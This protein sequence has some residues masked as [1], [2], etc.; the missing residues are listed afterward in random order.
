MTTK[1]KIALGVLGAAAAGV[2]IGLLIAP[3]KGSD[4]RKRVKKTA[5]SWADTLSHLFVNGKEGLKD[6]LE[7]AKEKGRHA[8]SAA[9][10]KVN[11][12]KESY[13]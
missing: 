7:E 8:R 2:V 11:K 10:E 4:M 13:S 1:A 9:E 3:E 6:G 5:G 12:I